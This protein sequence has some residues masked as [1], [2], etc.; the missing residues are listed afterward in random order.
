MVQA[1]KQSTATGDRRIEVREL[2]L[3]LLA[4]VQ[5]FAHGINAE[6]RHVDILVCNAGIM[7]PPQRS[8]TCDGFEKQFQVSFP[9]LS[10]SCSFQIQHHLAAQI[11]T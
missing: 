9:F 11:A 6:R 4:S 2:D 5:R 10:F 8:K 1:I 7:A 3:A